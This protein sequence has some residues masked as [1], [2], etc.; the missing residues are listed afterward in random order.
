MR[1]TAGVAGIDSICNP[2]ENKKLATLTV[3]HWSRRDPAR[4]KLE[5]R[6]LAC[7]TRSLS[8]SL[9]RTFT[10]VPLWWK[11]EIIRRIIRIMAS[12]LTGFHG[13]I[14]TMRPPRDQSIPL[15]IRDARLRALCQLL[16][17]LCSI[18][19]NSPSPPPSPRPSPG[20][21][22]IH[23]YTLTYRCTPLQY[24]NR[25]LVSRPRARAGTTKGSFIYARDLVKIANPFDAG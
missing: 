20:S 10:R 22:Y 19:S 16:N 4:L 15:A 14:S 18:V 3:Q 6:L 5:A 2:E 9:S 8:L 1:S 24:F 25:G 13:L 7:S 11:N 21:A 12:E 17:A 23:V